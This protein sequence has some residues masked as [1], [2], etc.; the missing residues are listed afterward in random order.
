MS[1]QVYEDP[2]MLDSTGLAMVTKLEA[3]K[4]AVQP[5]NAGTDIDLLIPSSGWTSSSPYQYTYTNSHITSG[6]MVKVN[7]LE[8]NNYTTP[9]YL[10]FEKITNGIIFTAPTKPTNDISVRVHIFSADT[11]STTATNAEAVSTSAV[12]GANNVEDALGS[13]SNQIGK[14]DISSEIS[15]NTTFS[16]STKKMYKAGNVVTLVMRGT[17]TVSNGQAIAT[18]SSNYKP[19]VER[20]IANIADNDNGKPIANA[21]IWI[22]GDSG[23]IVYYG[24]ALTS[25]GVIITA[26]YVI[27]G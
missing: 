13:L 6:C 8:G 17:A 2:V 22:S 14:S 18:I 10:N 16:P 15:A 21:C 25:K 20:F 26:T 1:A 12:S 3:I 4:N 23:Q 9:L 11:T 24:D 7:F 19:S 27:N 5:V